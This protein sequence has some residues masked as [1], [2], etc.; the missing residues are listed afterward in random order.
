MHLI[1]N[2]CTQSRWPTEA[3]RE[4]RDETS[5]ASPPPASWPLVPQMY[6][7][8]KETLKGMKVEGRCAWRKEPHQGS[9]GAALSAA[10]LTD[11]KMKAKLMSWL[12]SC[13]RRIESRTVCKDGL[14]LHAVRLCQKFNLHFGHFIHSAKIVLLVVKKKI[15]YNVRFAQHGL[16]SI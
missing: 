8:F 12:Y 11:E 5:A 16:I 6:W 15:Y 10:L 2:I 4:Q 1:C 13:G 7:E 14:F 3:K 9:C